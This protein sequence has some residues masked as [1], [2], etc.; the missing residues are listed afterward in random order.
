M[1]DS[2][3][4]LFHGKQLSSFRIVLMNW[5]PIPWKSLIHL[6]NL[7]RWQ[8]L[9]IYIHAYRIMDASMMTANFEPFCQGHSPKRSWNFAKTDSSPVYF[10]LFVINVVNLLFFCFELMGVHILTLSECILKLPVV[11]TYIFL[12]VRHW[13]HC[14]AQCHVRDSVEMIFYLKGAKKR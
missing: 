2:C 11:M 7:I 8:M 6:Y 12:F 10:M 4:F 14:L 3:C 9:S 5:H 13:C 1:W